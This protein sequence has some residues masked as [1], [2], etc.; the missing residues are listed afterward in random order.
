MLKSIAKSFRYAARGL[1]YCVKYERNFRI[2]LTV[3]FYVLIFSFMYGLSGEGFASLFSVFSLVLFAEAA[4]TAIEALVDANTTFF[5]ISAR[6]AKDIAA[7]AVLIT[8]LF[9]VCTGIS[10]FHD[11]ARII[12]AL[13]LMVTYPLLWLPFTMSVILAVFFIKGIKIRH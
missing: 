12:K 3:L 10:L 9:A 5:N 8:A 7:G 1:L 2:H 13:S 6:Y 11:V 4:N